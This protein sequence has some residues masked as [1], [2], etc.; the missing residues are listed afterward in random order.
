M[1]NKAVK[2]PLAFVSVICV[3]Y[4]D[5][6]IVES[7]V[8]DTIRVLKSNFHNYELIIVDDGSTDS[9]RTKISHLLEKYSSIRYLRLSK[10]FGDETAISAGLDNVI[11]DYIIILNPD[12][13]PPKLIPVFVNE[14]KAGSPIV[15]GVNKTPNWKMSPFYRLGR[16]FFHYLSK[17]LF[18]FTPLVSI[19]YCLAFSRQT[20]N[21]LLKIRDKTCF[22]HIQSSKI[23]LSKKI[24][25]YNGINRR[26]KPK[27]LSFSESFSY[28]V[29]A[30]VANSNIP[31][32]IASY[33]FAGFALL[34][35][36]FL[37]FLFLSS[38]NIIELSLFPIFF[39]FSLLF[40]CLSVF[41]V[42]LSEYFIGARKDQNT[43]QAYFV[44]EERNSSVMV[45][46]RKR[47]K[48]VVSKAY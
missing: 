15:V 6:Q 41:A 33:G 28:A 4:N 40:F 29:E 39:L 32:R 23:G 5:S 27:R 12:S 42:V 35:V 2:D 37:L 8:D 25:N 16:F 30:I 17:M 22:L 48:N 31:L 44:L 10:R 26:K 20:L 19:S 9:T 13:D 43:G 38:P 14:I 11:G 3:V 18:R 34:L 1:R 46:Q 7:F 21:S 47:K 36:F 45:A 24:I